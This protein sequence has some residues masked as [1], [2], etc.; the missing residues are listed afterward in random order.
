MSGSRIYCVY[1]DH[2]YMPRA[3]TLIQTMR[4]HGCTDP[5]WLYALTDEGLAAAQALKL[6]NTRILTRLDLET[7]YPALAR[8]KAD[9]TTLEYYYT[10]SPLVLD[11]AMKQVPEAQSVTYL[12]SDLAFFDDPQRVFDQIGDAP[13]AIIPHNFPHRLRALERFGKYNVGLVTFQRSPEGIACLEWWRDACLEWC[14]GY[15]EGEK[16][17]DQGYLTQFP[18]IAPNT[19]ILLHKGCNTAPWNIENYRVHLENGQVFL[20]EDPL[21]FFHF[22]GV[23]RAMGSYYFDSHRSYRAPLPSIVRN[24]IYRPYVEMLHDNELRQARLMPFLDMARVKLRGS[25]LFGIDLKNVRRTV[26]RTVFQLL[27]L[28]AGRAIPVRRTGS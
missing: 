5:V 4:Q 19:K 18:I 12:D 15:Q 21:V 17:G 11:Y 2:R 25:K 20:D 28:A 27:D 9:R 13:V 24:H 16:W 6:E 3:A 14:H 8:V 7:A 1:S 23:H 10:C 22:Q 26:I